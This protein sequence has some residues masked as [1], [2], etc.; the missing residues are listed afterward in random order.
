MQARI[1]VLTLFV[2]AVATGSAHAQT[3]AV[4]VKKAP[5]KVAAAHTIKLT[6]T[7]TAI[8]PKTREVTLK[9][10]EGNEVTIEAGPRVKNFGQMKVG[11]KVNAEYVE[12]LSIELKKGGG[13]PVAVTEHAG[14]G[15]AKAGKMPAGAA[16]RTVTVVA[17][18]VGLDPQAQTITLRGPQHT[19]DVK[20]RDPEQFKLIAKGDQ[21][22]ATYAEALAMKVERVKDAPAKK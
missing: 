20:V 4:A 14:A 17:D 22:E 9:G 12:A 3:G 13:Q 7:I 16:G 18:V 1:L 2:C 21:V 5:G 11:D 10:P 19:V 6:A 15:S 8:D